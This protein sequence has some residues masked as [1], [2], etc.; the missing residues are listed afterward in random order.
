MTGGDQAPARGARVAAAKAAL[1]ERLADFT[2][3]AARARALSR[4]YDNYWL[5]FDS[6]RAGAPCPADAPR[7]TRAGELLTLAAEHQRLPRRDRDH[8][9][10][11]RPCRPVLAIR[12]RHRHVGRLHRR[13]QGL[14]HHPTVSRWTSF[15]CRTPK[16]TAFDDPERLGRLRQTIEKTLRGE[17]W[18]RRA[19]DRPG[20]RCKT[21]ASAFTIT[22]K[23][24]FDNEASQHRHA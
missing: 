1:A 17:I 11:P 2:P 18:P 21:R 3:E 20:G 24:H 7:P 15:R 13:R 4:H 14:H 19:L 8:A 9:L 10:H 16:A 22:P 23:V 6:R 5:A 12:R